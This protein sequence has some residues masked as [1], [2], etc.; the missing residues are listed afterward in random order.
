[1][2]VFVGPVTF[3]RDNGVDIVLRE[4]VNPVGLFVVTIVRTAVTVLS[5]RYA[6]DSTQANPL[7]SVQSECPLTAVSHGIDSVP[8]NAIATDP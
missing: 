3:G 2:W 6:E 7:W 4:G 5:W 8:T 1:M